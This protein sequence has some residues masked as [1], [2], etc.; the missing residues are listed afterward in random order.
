MAN[1]D[2][3]KEFSLHQ[4][5]VQEIISANDIN[6]IQ[7]EVQAGEENVFEV[8]DEQFLD[9]CLFVLDNHPVV[10]ALWFDNFETTNNLNMASFTGLQF[11]TEESAVSLA[12]TYT[13][14]TVTTMSYT[15][16]TGSSI[17][18]LILMVEDYVPA[19]SSISYF[20][21]NDGGKSWTPIVKNK[22]LVTAMPSTGT[23]LQ[24]Q[25]RLQ[26]TSATGESPVVYAVG[27]LYEDAVYTPY[28][29]D[30]MPTSTPFNT[31]IRHTDLADVLPDQHHPQV[32]TH[33]GTDGSGRVF[34]KD[35]MGITEDDHHPKSIGTAD[36]LAR[37]NG[38]TLAAKLR[39]LYRSG[40]SRLCYL[41]DCQV[42]QVFTGMTLSV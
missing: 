5:N 7:A 32:H 34:H 26:R 35:L 13:A 21:S 29:P 9:R 42:S 1:N 22:S 39:V 19:N 8:R 11:K 28:I 10:N 4:D 41:R 6:S 31:V 37:M 38:S 12:D 36:Y 16:A 15:P 30:T 25:A 20:V 17:Q 27:L 3:Y 23:S 33:D 18:S 40:I 24:I 14:G 2:R